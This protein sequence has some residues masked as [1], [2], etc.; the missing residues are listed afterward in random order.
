[1]L[2]YKIELYKNIISD[3]GSDESE[4]RDLNENA[5]ITFGDYDRMAVS[6]TTAFSR[7]RDMSRLSRTWIGDRQTILLY[8]LSEDNEVVYEDSEGAQGFY[9]I[10][11]GERKR[12]ACLFIGVTI[13][14]FRNS[15]AEGE[16]NASEY[17][18]ASRSNIL[19]IVEEERAKDT[20]S[21][22]C[23]VFGV[24]GSYGVAVIWAADQ[25]T[26]VLSLI[27]KIKGVDV[28]PGVDKQVAGYPYLSIYTIFTKNNKAQ[29]GK[30]EQIKGKAML[31]ITLQTGLDQEMYQKLRDSLGDVA[32]FHSVGE[33]D[34]LII[35]DAKILY[36]LYED[37]AILDRDSV[38]HKQYLLQTNTK[39]CAEIAQ[40]DMEDMPKEQVKPL[41]STLP[42][43]VKK[44]NESRAFSLE[45]KREVYDCYQKLRILFFETFPKTAGMVDSLDLL[46]GDYLSKIATASNKMWTS[47]FIY[48]FHTILEIIHKNLEKVK[49]KVEIHGG[50]VL[51]D[52]REIL[53]CFEH[54]IIHIAE[55]NNLM[56]ETPKC[57]LR[58][59]GQNNLTLYAYFGIVK[60]ILK[61][62]YSMQDMS[63]QCEIVPLISVDTVPIIESALFQEYGGAM[64]KGILKLNLPMMALYNIPVYVPYL[65]H[66]I[67]HYVAPADRAVR[68]WYKGNLLLILAMKNLVTK[69]VSSRSG[70]EDMQIVS[71]LIDRVFMPCIY[72]GV[73]ERRY[74][75]IPESLKTGNELSRGEVKRRSEKEEDVQNDGIGAISSTWDCYKKNLYLKLCRDID[76]DDEITQKRNIVYGVL[77]DF[78]VNKKNIVRQAEGWVK[79]E[80]DL[81][82]DYGQKILA[83]MEQFMDTLSAMIDDNIEE[84]KR[85]SYQ[86]LIHSVGMSKSAL[87]ELDELD[88]ISSSLTEVICDVAMVELAEMGVAEYLLSYVKIQDDLLKDRNR[89]FQKQDVFRIGAIIDRLYNFDKADNNLVLLKSQKD[90]F[91]DLYIGLYF[92]VNKFGHEENDNHLGKLMNDADTWFN[93]IVQWYEQYMTEFN[94]YN[95]II[96]SITDQYSISVRLEEN[97]RTVFSHLE[98][99]RCYEEMRVYGKGIRSADQDRRVVSFEDRLGKIKE[100]RR[101]FRS[102]T[103]AMNISIIQR[104]Q[105]QQDFCKIRKICEECFKQDE[106]YHLHLR[107]ENAEKSIGYPIWMNPDDRLDHEKFS[108]TYEVKTIEELCNAIRKVSVYFEK[109][110]KEEYVNKSCNLWYRGH[111]SD[112]YKL[113]PSAMRRWGATSNHCETLREYQRAKYEE[114]KF[115]MDDASEVIDTSAYTDCDYLALMQHYGAPTIYLD[116]S[117]NAIAALYFALEAYIDTKKS[118][119]KN[120]EDAVLYIVHPN[121]YNKARNELMD[122][123]TRNSGKPLERDMQLT[124]QR[125]TD[126]LPNLSV[127]YNRSKHYMFLLGETD[128]DN[129]PDIN[130]KESVALKKGEGALLYLPLAIYS[131][132]A[133][134]RIR[135]QYGMFMAFNIFTPPDKLVKFEY[136][137]LEEIQQTYLEVFKDKEPFMYKVIIKNESK[138]KIADWLKA[139]GISKDMI[140]PELSNIGERI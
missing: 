60:D 83:F 87:I 85:E 16:S 5:Y 78:Y 96:K 12:S 15:P 50:R 11:E 67:F 55:S 29:K 4:N 28:T 17:I 44:N 3:D 104:Y 69:I 2:G 62:I 43:R 10:S 121:L 97:V 111:Q 40:T 105:G 127:E 46:Y 19:K 138:K 22:Y 94:I 119:E 35:V 120:S 88:E 42:E 118:S 8:E 36:G 126:N 66:E 124:K 34:L 13:L 77:H 25:Y 108:Y 133:N 32:Q 63:C 116:W 135:N 27:N 134:M 52:F 37:N 9:I 93:K 86:K 45:M 79:Q 65:F 7:M 80:E 30:K 59:T 51:D 106:P 75:E 91:I 72:E 115:R 112:Q 82:R 130:D 70:I 129:I 140:Y 109:R 92:S 89:G 26:K 47:D 114:F 137:A 71:Q 24:L 23:S 6:K 58:Y 74:K 123:V 100:A 139:I 90:D 33:Y 20:E 48:Q 1:M 99:K 81:L 101:V 76:G 64:S 98:C 128:C 132:R 102:K 53:N 95:I 73:R 57:H 21:V 41:G 14:Q 103:F 68:N 110:D 49:R 39:L 131:S 117:E 31:R 122:T 61:L 56:L 136:M 84:K 113:L 54:Q 107:E 125:K 18:N 38:F